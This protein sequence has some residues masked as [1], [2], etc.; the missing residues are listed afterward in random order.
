MASVK[1]ASWTSAKRIMGNTV[2]HRA[3]SIQECNVITAKIVTALKRS[4]EAKISSTDIAAT[5]R[6]RQGEI[7]T[8]GKN[9]SIPFDSDFL[10]FLKTDPSSYKLREAVHLRQCRAAHQREDYHE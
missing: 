1:H 8:L 9:R 3:I 7:C 10:T 5:G 4:R 6:P 2:I